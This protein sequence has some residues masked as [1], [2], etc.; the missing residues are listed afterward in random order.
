MNVVGL[1][2]YHPDAAAALFRDGQLV[3]A[4]EEE[5]YSR[6]KHASGFP[7]L[8]LQHCLIE[9]NLTAAEIDY[10]AISKDPKANFLQKIL[11]TL[12]N[13]PA[14]KL[15]WD[16]SKAFEK[17]ATFRDDFL[18]A[19]DLRGD[20]CQAK[21]LHIEHH[22]NHAAST[23]FVSGFQEAAFLSIDGLGDFT[24]TAWGYGSGSR[25]NIL[26]KVFFPHSAGFLYTAA[27]Q[28]L[29]FHGF[30][31]EYKV[32]GL[33]SYG[34][35][36]YID[37]ARKVY[38]LLPHGQFKL[39]LNY[40]MHQKGKAKIQWDGGKPEQDILF[41]N[42]WSSLFGAPRIP[43]SAPTQEE[44]DIAAS[45]QLA[46]EEIYFHVLNHLY[47]VTETPY[48]CLAGGVAFNCVANGKI[49][50]QT[51]FKDV[52]I[53][54]AAGDAGTALG[55][56]AYASY[57]IAKQPRHFVM[58]HS[59]WG[60]EGRE[61]EIEIALKKAGVSYEKLETTQLVEK[62]AQALVET[63]IVGWYQGRMEFGPRA[64]GNR[65]ILADARVANIRD[66]L[67]EKIKRRE[68][69]RP[70]APIVLEE[71]A[72]DYFEM[73]CAKSPFMLKV[74]AV[75]EEKKKIIPAVTHVDGSARVQTI[76]KENQPLV[77]SL[78][79]AFEKK[80]GVPVLLNTSFNEHE[81]IVCTPQEALDCYLKTQMDVLVMGSFFIQRK[82]N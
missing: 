66:V 25:I 42:E 18:R 76:S 62:T 73:D 80:T 41:S 56:A 17:S 23:F 19:L 15:L 44:M 7:T 68:M 53:Q 79:E 46:L 52:Y 64:L 3:W 54:P 28:F 61:E 13:R 16:R 63:K 58:N 59:M 34:V 57:V 37:Q 29:G 43:G 69:F 50:A 2:A 6:I 24:S 27:T 8:A 51:P 74:F 35:P 32:M 60:T 36:R 12:K 71:K 72:H 67:N 82:A 20:E 75:K 30:G 70:F 77:W 26:G 4:A 22:L 39:N 55:A 78:L 31:D 45:F 14:L 38:K 1:N 11:F 49:S 81:P 21:F 40:F 65:S 5:R 33:A 48:L 47:R 9:N 10:V